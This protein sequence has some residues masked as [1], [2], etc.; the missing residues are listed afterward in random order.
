MFDLFGKK[1]R[2]VNSIDD[3]ATG[4]IVQLRFNDIAG[5][6]NERIIVKRV[7]TLIDTTGL[8]TRLIA[9]TTGMPV[10]IW[11]NKRH[12]RNTVRISRELTR[13][14]V[15]TIFSETEFS[16]IFDE[17]FTTLNTRQVPES[18]QGWISTV[19]YRE[20]I[21]FGSLDIRDYDYRTHGSSLPTGT[22]RSC[23]YYRLDSDDNVYSIDVEVYDNDQTVVFATVEL[24]RSSIEDIYPSNT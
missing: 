9:E 23:D 10:W 2:V 11:L 1:K 19:G 7:E 14:E 6:S 22:V 17:G 13:A 21:D 12:T 8:S 16:T 3:V 4:D 15:L 18:L 5:L 20:T 24:E